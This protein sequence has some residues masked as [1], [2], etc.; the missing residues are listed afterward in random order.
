MGSVSKVTARYRGNV[1]YYSYRVRCTSAAPSYFKPFRSKRNCRGYLDGALYHNNPVR[2]ADL[3]RRLIW[4]DS[5]SFHPDILLSIGTSCNGAIQADRDRLHSYRQEFSH[6][7]EIDQHDATKKQWPISKTINI[8]K[9]RVENILD[10]EMTWLS[11]MSEA[12]RGDE[13]FKTRYRRINPNR[14]RSPS[15]GRGEKV[16]ALAAPDAKN[17]EVWRIPKPS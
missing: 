10:A 9:S 16:V 14:G 3:E 12:A 15:T 4:P 2:V 8:L 1:T 11:F 7:A 13:D 6:E 5:E 17:R